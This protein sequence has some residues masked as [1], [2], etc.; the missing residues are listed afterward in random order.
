MQYVEVD[1]TNL[2]VSR[3]AFGTASLHHLYR[4]NQRL[5]LLEAA[6]ASGITHFDTSPYYGFGLAES[7]LGA[8]IRGRRDAVTIAT[9]V[10]LYTPGRA[11]RG[12]L[13]LWIRKAAGKICGRFSTPRVDW[14]IRAAE[15]SLN[16][17][18][19][20]L[21]TDYVDLLFLHEPD[22]ILVR[23]E[24]MLTWLEGE[25]SKGKIRTWGLAGVPDLLQGWVRADHPLAR[26]VQTKDSLDRKE[27]D[28]V[29]DQGR[30]LQFTYGYLSASPVGGIAESADIL[31]RKALERNQ[32]GAILFS[33]RRV[34][35]ITKL[36]GI[37]P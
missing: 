36:V 16:A 6:L 32:D 34:D 27:A 7:D 23:S 10:G 30:R 18:L 19:K 14:S 12:S 3:L 22:P 21:G 28:L 20:R 24:E 13:G 15:A 37:V 8:F 9:K 31:M 25:R 11:V 2:R 5:R 26:V 4:K 17:S 35:R 33:T 29:L 1:N